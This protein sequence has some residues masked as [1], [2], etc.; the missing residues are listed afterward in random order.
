[1]ELAV[2]IFSVLYSLGALVWMVVYLIKLNKK[3]DI[4]NRMEY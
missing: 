1:M 2:L 3:V 4:Y